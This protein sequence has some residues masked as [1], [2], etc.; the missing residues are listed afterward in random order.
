[1]SWQQYHMQSEQYAGQAEAAGQ[2][3]AFARA[4][5]LYRLAAEQEELALAGL[6]QS[7]ARTLGVTA[8]SAAS[9]WYKAGIYEKARSLAAH[10]LA[11]SSLPPFAEKQLQQILTEVE[12]VEGLLRSLEQWRASVPVSSSDK[13]MLVQAVEQWKASAA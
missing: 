12:K 2:E 11:S 4:Q 8:V 9:L 5:Q 7:K 13:E 1:M 3:R 6:D 10:W